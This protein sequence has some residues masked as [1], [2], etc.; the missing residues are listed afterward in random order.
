MSKVIICRGLP[1]SGKSTYSKA[2]ASEDPINRIRLNC[3]DI[4]IMLGGIDNYW[5]PERETLVWNIFYASLNF[6]RYQKYDIIIDNMNLSKKDVGKILSR[7]SGETISY[8]DFFNVPLDELI[9]RDSKRD[10][11]VGKDVLV[12][13]YNKYKVEYGF[14]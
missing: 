13:L 1:A 3:D 11:S 9:D 10:K 12:N 2:W 5:V 4:R 7:C 6:A 8:K 14:K